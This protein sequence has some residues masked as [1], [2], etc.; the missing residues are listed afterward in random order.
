MSIIESLCYIHRQITKNVRALTQ[1]FNPSSSPTVNEAFPQRAYQLFINSV[2]VP[3]SGYAQKNTVTGN[4]KSPDPFGFFQIPAKTTTKE[5]RNTSRSSRLPLSL[6]A[7]YSA[8][9]IKK[10]E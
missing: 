7:C 2:N 9:Y 3:I 5:K 10:K 8:R 6:L 1:S 4:K